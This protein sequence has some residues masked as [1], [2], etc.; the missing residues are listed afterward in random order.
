MTNET[1]LVSGI[2]SV[3]TAG[4]V[5]GANHL[6][7]R[8]Y[9]WLVEREKY[10]QAIFG[11]KIK[12]DREISEAVHKF[13][14]LFADYS[15]CINNG[16]CRDKD[17]SAHV[18][19]AFEAATNIE[20]SVN[21]NI[22]LFPDSTVDRITKLQAEMVLENPKSLIGID[23]VLTQL[24]ARTLRLL[25]ILRDDLGINEFGEKLKKGFFHIF[26]IFF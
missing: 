24:N 5:A 15:L 25:D 26:F 2:T 18:S 9:L 22:F 1:I 7:N 3:I 20:F 16:I 21:R 11:E 4:L 23:T 10:R 17:L 6:L 19:A 13:N 8:R 12:A 14:T